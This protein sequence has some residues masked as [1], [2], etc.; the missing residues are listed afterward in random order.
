[1]KKVLFVNSAIYLPGEGGYKRTLYLFDLMKSLNYKVTLLTSD[2]NHYNKKKREVEK[3]YKDYP[4]YKDIV[5]LPKMPYKK[6]ISI[7]RYL[8]GI[9]Y[10][11]TAMKWIKKHINEY[12]LIYLNMPDTKIVNNSAKLCKKYKIPMIIDVRDL[13][14]EALKVVLKNKIL[15][16]IL[17]FPMKVNVDRAYSKA[18]ELI[19]VSQ[20]YLE[21]GLKVNKKAKN[22]IV[23]YLGATLD[24]FDAGIKK[25]S[26]EIQKNKDEFWISYAG[27][28]GSSYDLITIIKS[29]DKIK[30]EKNINVILKILG[31]GP[32][33]EAL[34]KYVKEHKIKNVDFM[35][36]MDYEKMAAYLSKSDITVNCIKRNAS[37]S[38]IN[39]VADYFASGV[40]MLNSCINKEMQW[41]IDNYK[42]GLNYEPE[43]E[44]DFIEKFIKLYN[45]N[46]IRNEYGHNARKLAMEKFNR[47]NSYK[48][49]IK[50][51]E[52]TNYRG[53]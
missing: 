19:A 2:F 31:H 7:K 6:N 15:Y 22:P 52:K 29:V 34:K 38:I 20:E 33:E 32:D 44:D 46:D 16:N 10:G 48:E 28:I 21:R 13:R 36:F 9:T 14:P 12:D 51:I 4:E 5:I 50:T 3:F 24:K 25:Y 17:T 53:R 18:D 35:G 30:K 26:K 1:M 39:K 40:P 49:I 42:T 8:S 45:N 27:T 41:L 47:E 23:V 11:N 37:Q 43:N